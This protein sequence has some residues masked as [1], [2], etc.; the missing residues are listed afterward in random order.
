[1]KILSLFLFLNLAIEVLISISTTGQVFPQDFS[2]AMPFLYIFGTTSVAGVK[3]AVF[4]VLIPISYLLMV[5]AALLTL[6]RS[7]KYAFHVATTLCLL[8][9]CLLDQRGSQNANLELLSMGL[10]GVLAGYLPL[11]KIN[12]VVAHRLAMLGSYA[13][14]LGAITLWNTPYPLQIVGVCLTLLVLYAAGSRSEKPSALECHIILLGK[15]SLF[16]Y[17]AQMV[18]LQTMH[19]FVR[20]ID[21]GERGLLI[22]FVLGFALTMAS[23]EL[24]DRMRKV[25]PSFDAGYKAVFA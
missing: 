24:V 7:Y 3:A 16:G 9:I 21:L 25:S 4:Y 5:S 12:W 18:F 22:S 10:L 14:Y 1:V 11:T 8:T 20:F 23:I 13:V 19:R 2:V 17:I 6:T 15:Y